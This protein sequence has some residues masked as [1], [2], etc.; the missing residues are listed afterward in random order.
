MAGI[1]LLFSATEDIPSSLFGYF[2]LEISQKIF[3]HFHFDIFL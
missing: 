2:V 3:S 1:I